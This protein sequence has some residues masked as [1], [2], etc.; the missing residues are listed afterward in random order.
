[1]FL[2]LSFHSLVSIL[3]HDRR[4]SCVSV[5]WGASERWRSG[6]RLHKQIDKTLISLLPATMSS[7]SWMG[8]EEGRIDSAL[9]LYELFST[10]RGRQG[11]W[12]TSL[13]LIHNLFSFSY[14]TGI[15]IEQRCETVLGT[16]TVVCNELSQ[17]TAMFNIHKFC[18]LS[19]QC[20]YVFRVDLRTNSD[21][22]NQSK[23]NKCTFFIY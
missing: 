19:T 4:H 12:M 13:S 18:V 14:V 20:I 21:Y 7:H 9:I 5:H 17:A 2:Y 1:M 8:V 6:R 23:S 11:V 3:W 16:A 15:E 22:F 10:A